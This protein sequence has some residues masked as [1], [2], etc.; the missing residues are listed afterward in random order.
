MVGWIE[1]VRIYPGNLVVKAKLD[2][3]AKTCSLNALNITEF[4]RNGEGWIRFDVTTRR[5]EKVTLERKLHRVAKIKRKKAKSQK[6]P[7]IRLGICLGRSYKEV[8]VNLVDRRKFNYPL[9]VGRSF[10]EGDF[11]V[12]PSEKYTTE[13]NCHGVLDR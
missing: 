10:I 11:M 8:E 4:D 7:V 3:G 9:L 1:K 12:D 2:T 13:P 6:R 5:G